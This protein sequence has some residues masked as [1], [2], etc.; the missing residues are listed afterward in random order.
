MWISFF[1]ETT[2]GEKIILCFFPQSGQR[3]KRN[4]KMQGMKEFGSC[5]RQNGF[6]GRATVKN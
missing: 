6:N 3:A 2:P 4:K 5:Q 1:S